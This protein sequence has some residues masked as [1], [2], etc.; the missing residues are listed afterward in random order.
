MDAEDEFRDAKVNF[1]PSMNVQPGAGEVGLVGFVR[2]IGV[3]R[4]E[5]E[6]VSVLT[7]G[8]V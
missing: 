7:I 8:T 5:F 2:C 4:S 6:S 3:G 1:I